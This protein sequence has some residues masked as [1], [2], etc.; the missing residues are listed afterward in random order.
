M[1][2]AYEGQ[3][4]F[5][6]YYHAPGS[7]VWLNTGRTTCVA[8]TQRDGHQFAGD[9]SGVASAATLAER[10]FARGTT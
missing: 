7:G 8:E 6:W 3:N 5:T 10:G 1:R 4:P 2:E 9:P